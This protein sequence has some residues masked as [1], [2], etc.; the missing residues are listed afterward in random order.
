MF[1]ITRG[2]RISWANE[3][4]SESLGYSANELSTLGIATIDESLAGPAFDEL[5]ARLGRDRAFH[6][7]AS[8]RT[9]AGG[10]LPVEVA[11]AHLERE[12]DTPLAFF[13][14]RDVSSRVAEAERHRALETQLRHAQKMEA[15]GTLAGGIAHDFNNVLAA[16]LGNVEFSLQD[17]HLPQD[18][19]EALADVQ[20][21]GG[22]A[23]ALVGRLSSMS[24]REE[25]RLELVDV[26]AVLEEVARLLRATL[27]ATIQLALELPRGPVPLPADGAQLHQA[28]VNLGTNAA[29]A[30]KGGGTLSMGVAAVSLRPAEA[31]RRHVALRP[32][33]YIRVHVRDTGHGMSAET[34]DRIFEPFFTTKPPGEGTGLGLAVVHGIVEGHQ[35]AIVV[36]SAPGQGT[37]FELYFPATSAKF[38]PPKPAPTETVTR[39]TLRVLLV[40]DDTLVLAACSRTLDR[41]GCRVTAV[42]VPE[43][44]LALLRARPDDY[45]V[46]VTDVTMPGLS[47]PDLARAFRLVRPGFPVVAI[48]GYDGAGV[49]QALDDAGVQ[50]V[51]TKPFTD[52]VLVATLARLPG[53]R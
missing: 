15:I 5:W 20:T 17:E 7:E 29:H 43:E 22:R 18:V 30:M 12:G 44:A 53:R 46:L 40:D 33:D 9:R 28:L 47:G 34:K 4:A 36:D 24:R 42:S 51:L 21:A 1:M 10:V 11:V 41:A 2:G 39:L 23:R 45:D 27:P 3:A 25:P 19:R 6:R 26:S 52:A 49:R 35:G 14:V 31:K 48:T 50:D 16:I 8:H 13:H 37:T 32:D 38:T